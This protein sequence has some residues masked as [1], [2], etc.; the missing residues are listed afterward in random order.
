MATK[1]IKCN[2]VNT[3]QDKHYGKNK[4]VYNENNIQNRNGSD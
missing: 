2:C 3:Y 4:R 1:I